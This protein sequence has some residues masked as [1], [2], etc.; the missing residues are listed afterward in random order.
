MTKRSVS[1]P[2]KIAEDMLHR[3]ISEEYQPGR[4]LPSERELQEEYQVSRTVVREAIKL[5]AAR[6]VISINSRQG[7]VVNPDLISPITNALLL[8][9][10]R[11]RAYIED[12]L[13]IRQLLE[14]QIAMLAAQSATAAQIR[15]LKNLVQNLEITLFSDDEDQQNKAA[16]SWM[17]QDTRFHI[18]LAEA[19]QNPVMAILIEVIVGLLWRQSSMIK[20]TLYPDHRA[21]VIQQHAA[22]AEAVAAKDPERAHQTMVEHLNYTKLYIASQKDSLLNLD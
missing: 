2:V 10:L 3:I 20:R 22:I 13:A 1:L 6:G 15:D 18:L 12:V 17:M 9:C 16:E 8:A 19:T 5:L 7:A 21:K 14:P 11:S 4:F